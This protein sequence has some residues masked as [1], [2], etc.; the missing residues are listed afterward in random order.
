[1][2]H[3]LSFP[4]I[5]VLSCWNNIAIPTLYSSSW[6]CSWPYSLNIVADGYVASWPCS[7]NIV[8]DGSLKGELHFLGTHTADSIDLNTLTKLHPFMGH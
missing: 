5:P 7:L 3:K 1:M 8:A 4:D 6:L 2:H